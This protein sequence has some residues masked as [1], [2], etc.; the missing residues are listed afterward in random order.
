MIVAA[1][2]AMTRPMCYRARCSL[3]RAIQGLCLFRHRAGASILPQ[4]AAAS[5]SVPASMIWCDRASI[6]LHENRA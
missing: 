3:M 2:G 6:L 5:H 4:E 1:S